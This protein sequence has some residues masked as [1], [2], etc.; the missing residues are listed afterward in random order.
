M[1]S[2]TIGVVVRSQ[3]TANRFGALGC[4][5]PADNQ[6]LDL[7]SRFEPALRTGSSRWCE[8]GYQEFLADHFE[9]TR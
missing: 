3:V 5:Q 8:S 4:H 6:L 7:I 2:V 9:H 1:R